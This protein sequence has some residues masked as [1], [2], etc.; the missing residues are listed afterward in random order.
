MCCTIIYRSG[1]KVSGLRGF[2]MKKAEGRTWPPLHVAGAHRCGPA[3]G[4]T[5]LG[6]GAE[7]PP[8]PPLRTFWEGTNVTQATQVAGPQ[9]HI[10]CSG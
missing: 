8:L 7:L 9:E 6:C 1:P 2:T 10:G 3:G 5:L 4:R